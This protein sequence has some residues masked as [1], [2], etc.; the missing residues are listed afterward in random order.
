MRSAHALAAASLAVG[1]VVFCSPISAGSSFASLVDD[2]APG[3]NPTAGYTDSAAALGEPTRFTGVGVFPSVVSPFSPPFMPNEIVSI[4]AGGHLALAF[5][6]PIT[7]NPSNPFGIDFIIFS[8]NGFIDGDFPIGLNIGAFGNDPYIV[9]VSE[10][11][12]SWTTVTPPTRDVLFPTLGYTD[13]GPFDTTPGSALTD[14]IKPVDPA[15]T[16]ADLFM[17]THAEIVALYDGSGGGAGYDLA[18]T[19]LASISYVR[20]SNPGDPRRTASVEID[21]ISRVTPT[22]SGS[23]ADFVTSDTFLPPADGVVDG[24]DLAVLLG[25][26]GT[27]PGSIADIVDTNTFQPPADGVVDGADLAYLLGEWTS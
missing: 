25:E 7:D 20:I 23:I 1:S 19:G 13:S 21:A 10:D 26:W 16:S 3:S 15:L 6:P 2:Y 17:L 22:A 4:G 24:A 11:G 27:N 8:N 14:F 9:E 18:G 12:V 5:D